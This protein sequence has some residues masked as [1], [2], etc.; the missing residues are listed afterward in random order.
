MTE[1]IREL[2]NWLISEYGKNVTGKVKFRVIWSEDIYEMRKGR[3]NEF[4]GKIFLREVI[5]VRKVKKY[6]YINDRFILEGWVDANMSHNGE[7]PEAVN[8]DFT[9]IYVFEN[10]RGK[11]LPVTR[12]A[13]AFMIASIQGRIRKDEVKDSEAQEIKEIE[14]Q[15]DTMLDAPD[16]ATHG[17][18]RNAVAYT[19]NLKGKKDFKNVT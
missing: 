18:T 19:K 6:A 17:V 16:F 7:V 3:F 5:G 8:G 12:K 9:P 15:V 14:N 1:E 10:S 2:N 4:Y 13:L 11:P